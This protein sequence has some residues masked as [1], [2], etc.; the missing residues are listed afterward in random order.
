MKPTCSVS[1]LCLILLV[2]IV[3]PAGPGLGAAAEDAP[4]AAERAPE[5]PSLTAPP[6]APAVALPPKADIAR[7]VPGITKRASSWAQDG[8]NKDF[9]NIGP[10]ETAVLMESDGPGMITHIYFTVVEPDVFDFRDAVLRMYWDGEETP[11]VEVPFGD[12][13]CIG[14]CAVRRFSS[15]MMAVY[16]GGGEKPSNS[17][18]NCY[19]PMPFA[20]HAR[21][22][23][24]N[25]SPERYFGGAYGG[26]W[27]HIEYERYD[28]PLP[29]DLGRFHAQWRNEYPTTVKDDDTGDMPDFM[30]GD[31]SRH[32]N[33][34]GED[35]YVMLEAEGEGHIAGL[36]LEV[37]NHQGGWY[38]E[39]DDMIF[40]DGEEWPPSLHGTGSEE[41]F[42]GGGT[43][44]QEY[45]GLYTGFLQVENRHDDTFN[46]RN[47][48]YR[49][50]IQDPIRFR[51][52]VRMSIEHGH[53]NQGENDY[54]SVA[55]W[56][57]KEP[58]APFP[59]LPPLE[60]RHPKYPD[61]FHA[62]REQALILYKEFVP[63]R[64]GVMYEGQEIPRGQRRALWYVGNLMNEGCKLMH[65]QD[66][67]GAKAVFSKAVE[68]WRSRSEERGR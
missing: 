27:Y 60:K 37:D 32:Q 35:N 43:P 46:G 36:F 28:A 58:H 4:G 29:D 40:I 34:T 9:V 10:G 7:I 5:Q 14:N 33:T 65:H 61:S 41:V 56:Y 8:G 2:Q 20:T 59:K 21:V 11:S 55:Y 22:E 1:I 26:L 38:G 3:A 12:F 66:Y 62:A 63:T 39:G 48:M 64:I 42:G 17:G 31:P 23:L 45:A 44:D 50:Y 52:S 25:E 57:Q 18:Y 54:A 24:F 13:F 68:I 16:P 15:I 67:E 6:D 19:F 30:G 47:A 49:W 51:K 53:N